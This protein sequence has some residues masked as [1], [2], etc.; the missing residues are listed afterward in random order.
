MD[1]TN[2]AHGRAPKEVY[3]YPL[4]R[5]VQRRLCTASPPAPAHGAEALDGP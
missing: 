5:E 3:V 2:Q 1:R 4:C